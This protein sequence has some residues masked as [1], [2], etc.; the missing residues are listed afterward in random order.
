M[1]LRLS[2]SEK[3]YIIE[4]RVREHPISWRT[5]GRNLKRSPS[6]LCSAYKRG[7][8]TVCK[9]KC[10]N[11]GNPT[12]SERQLCALPPCRKIYNREYRRDNWYWNAYGLRDEDVSKML[13][14]Q[15][16]VCIL[17]FCDVVLTP[18]NMHIDHNHD[19]NKV[20]GICCSRHNKGLGFFDDD[21]VKLRAAAAYLEMQ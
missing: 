11:C 16:G 7:F 6:N 9:F 14:A 8:M 19:T 1:S 20:R 12:N 3:E 13:M 10:I 15:G 5:I 18:R 17:A 21:P 2:Q 4:A